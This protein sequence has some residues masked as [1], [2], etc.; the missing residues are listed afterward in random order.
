MPGSAQDRMHRVDIFR[1]YAMHE[2]SRVSYL[3]GD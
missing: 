1:T 2:Q 3:I